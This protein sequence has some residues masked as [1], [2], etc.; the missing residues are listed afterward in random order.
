MTNALTE[1]DARG[2]SSVDYE[3][4]WQVVWKKGETNAAACKLTPEQNQRLLRTLQTR[5]DCFRIEFAA[6]PP[7]KVKPLKVRT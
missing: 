2:T 6:E 1:S 3:K 5:L 4:L 7:I